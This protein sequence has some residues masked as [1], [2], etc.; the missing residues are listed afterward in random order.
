MKKKRNGFAKLR[1]RIHDFN[2]GPLTV[3]VWLLAVGGA[4]SLLS[5]RASRF[6]Y[7][8]LARGVEYTI[9]SETGGRIE[10]LLVDLCDDVNA[11]D[12]VAILDDSLIAAEIETARGSVRALQ[13]ELD[14]AGAEIP[15]ENAERVSDWQSQLADFEA[16]EERYRV[17]AL[18][19]R[20]EIESDRVEAQKLSLEAER[21]RKLRETNTVSQ[22]DYD[23]IRLQHE[24]V[25]KRIAE[26]VL[27]AER[28]D[29]NCEEARVRREEFA[30]RQPASQDEA[31]QLAPLREAIRK[32]ELELEELRVRREAMLLRAPAVGRVTR[33]LCQAGQGVRAGEPI[34]VIGERTATE[35]I[36][37]IAEADATRVKEKMPVE[38]VR[39][40]NGQTICQASVTRIGESIEELPL[41]LWRHAQTP[42][43]GRCFLVSAP[44]SLAL[45]PGERI[46][47]RPLSGGI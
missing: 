24:Q 8:G 21:T 38:I 32:E 19:L 35:V 26:N 3:L 13:A 43:Y 7:I 2:R 11:G 37:Y 36:G 40:E 18:N 14:V 6:E 47:I 39:V 30:K 25:T 27:L 5:H 41:R 28:I 23:S 16:R 33:V 20:V 10:K 46:R 29:K 42:E 12:V 44:L 22:E 45:A 9:A 4:C 15:A 17:D 31:R 1:D 34:M